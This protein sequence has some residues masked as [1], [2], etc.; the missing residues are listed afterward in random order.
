MSDTTAPAA[1][2]AAR[3]HAVNDAIAAAA[4]RHGRAAGSVALVAVSKRQPAAAIRAAH[5]AGQRRFGENYL[6]EALAKQDELADLDLEWHFI[7][8][9]QSNK[10]ADIAA[11][12]DW[13]HT[14][15]REKIARR[16]NDQRPAGRAP[17]EVLVEVN[18]SG[19]ASKHGVT[20]QALPALLETLAALPRLRL[21]GLMAL[22]APAAEVAAQRRAF[23]ALAALAAASPVPLDTLSMG[24]SDDF[25]AAIAEGATLVRIGTAVFGP[26]PRD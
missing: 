25:E 1:H 14:V 5:A 9:I 13:V 23:A 15:D 12:F 17:L 18:I 22:P 2:V 26:R 21:R 10:T 20:P 6:Q 11:R 16:L 3:L 8:A 7:G 19:E 4:A 24:T